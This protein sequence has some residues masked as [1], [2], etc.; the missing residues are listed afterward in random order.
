MRSSTQRP[1]AIHRDFYLCIG[2]SLDS[3]RIWK[4]RPLIAFHDFRS[5]VFDQIFYAAGK[6]SGQ[7]FPAIPVHNVAKYRKLE[8]RKNPSHLSAGY[9][10]LILWGSCHGSKQPIRFIRTS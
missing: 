4:T 7:D 6:P 3:A 8:T 2:Q 5:A 1:Q 10:S 9:D